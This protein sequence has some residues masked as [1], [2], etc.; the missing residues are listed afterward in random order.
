MKRKFIVL[1]YRGDASRQT[2]ASRAA[3]AAK[4]GGVQIEVDVLS[5]K[6]AGKLKRDTSILAVAPVMPV[7]LIRPVRERK[8]RQ[9]ANADAAWGISAVR[10]DVSPFTGEGIVAAVLDTGIDPK[11][12]AFA[13]VK[14]TR[15]NFTSESADDV[16]GHGTHCAGTIFG[17]DVQGTQ[18]GVA[19]GISHAV[20]GKVI[21]AGG[22]SSDKI[23]AAMQWAAQSGAHII[24]MSLGIDFPGAVKELV[25]QGWPVD[26]A[27]SAALDGYRANV[28]L[29]ERLASLMR[30]H[31][32]FGQ[33]TLIVAAAGNESQRTVNEAYEIGVSPP[34]VSEGIISV[35]ALEQ[36][37]G[38]KFTVAPF[39]NVGATL[40]GPGVN[41]VSARLGGGLESLSGTSMATPHVA[42]VA[43]LWGEALIKDK[44]P[45]DPE[46][47]T[48]RVIA[49]ATSKKIAAG[50]EYADVGAG[51]V[52]APQ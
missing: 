17:R 49:S 30:T 31:A 4:S 16:D 9:A 35:A 5:A 25:E 26:L 21:G 34:A 39:S 3:A 40:A 19:R 10:A 42:G 28:L 6:A 18:I 37:A 36:S 52:Q 8:N 46:E 27:T 2:R 14:L 41:I 38:D 23:V 7:R 13:G 12:P 50:N 29:F 43:A 44:K 20:I 47:W 11:H 45:L 48:A 22:G 24:S 1:K 15:K 51:L 33:A 32:L